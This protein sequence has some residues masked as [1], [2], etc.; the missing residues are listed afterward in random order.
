MGRHKKGSNQLTIAQIRENIKS[1]LNALNHSLSEYYAEGTESELF[2]SALE[3]VSQKSGGLSKKGYLSSG[4]RL[5]SRADLLS[6]SK[7]LSRLRSWEMFTPEAE[8]REEER[9]KKAYKAFHKNHSD[10]SIEEYRQIGDVFRTLKDLD[11]NEIDS[12]QVIQIARK[13]L[14]KGMKAETLGKIIQRRVNEGRKAGSDAGSVSA[15][16]LRS[17]TYSRRNS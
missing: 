5:K 16:I 9:F 14:A 12:D 15:A 2:N 4:W 3:R 17:I 10:V 6:Y 7:E 8:R 13:A 1:D 11:I